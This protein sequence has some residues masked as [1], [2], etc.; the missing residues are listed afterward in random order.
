MLLYEKYTPHS[1][2]E[3]I[4]NRLGLERIGRFAAEAKAGKRP[5]P[6]MV[7]GPSGTGK[8]AA[9]RAAAE[10]GGFEVL[11][12]TSSDY[13]DADTL[14]KRLLPAAKSR[15][16]FSSVTLILFDEIDELSSRFDKGAESVV[17]QMLR[18][19]RQPIAFTAND[20]WDRRI[21]FLRTHV[22]RIEF[23]KADSKELIAYLRKVSEAEGEHLEEGV[24]REIAY[25]SDGDVRAALNDLE[26]VFMGGNDII[27]NLVVRNRK[28]EIFRLLDRIF[29]TNSF[30]AAKSAV[31]TSD[32]ELEML[33][34]WVDENIPNR[35]W[36]KK[37]LDQAYE[38]LSFAS[39]FFEMAE[40]VRYYGYVRYTN[41]GIAGVSI[42]S[43]G[44]TRY[45]NPYSFPSRVK[46]LSSTKESRGVQNRIAYKLSP[47]LHTNRH[48]IVS[49]YLPLFRRLVEKAPEERR[50]A[51]TESLEND[52]KLDKDEI[53]YFIAAS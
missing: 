37:S 33:I 45:V 13:R 50:T 8:T 28:V 30:L 6:I 48:E 40:R 39:R 20:F 7:Y 9:L 51:F 32:V 4:G 3:L 43:G 34:N 15:G 22:E 26:M 36:L 44:N 27:D 29:M 16:L 10:E 46:Y 25:R 42:S 14:K 1:L 11:E 21:S 17:T 19:A 23:R 18:E 49:S 41:V 2:K 47:Y 35:Y 38:Q 31:E 12:L 5:K 24:L 52:F 53:E